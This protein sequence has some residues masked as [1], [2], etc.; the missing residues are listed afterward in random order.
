[1]LTGGSSYLTLT[2]KIIVENK[3]IILLVDGVLIEQVL[4]AL[5]EPLNLSLQQSDLRDE[6]KDLQHF[7]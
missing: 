5:R 4:T 1:M 2:L 7:Q 6:D 3:N